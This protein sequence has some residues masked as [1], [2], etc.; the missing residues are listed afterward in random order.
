MNNRKLRLNRTDEDSHTL[1]MGDSGAGK[2]QLLYQYLDYIQASDELAIVLDSQREFLPIYFN[3]KRGDWVLNPKDNRCPYWNIFDEVSDITDATAIANSLFPEPANKSNEF[4]HI[5]TI[6]IFSWLL[7]YAKDPATGA[8]PN[9]AQLA[10]WLGNDEQMDKLIKGTDLV[11]KLPT[12]PTAGGQRA[13]FMATLS[14]ASKP[15]QLM[16]T[17]PEGRKR[18]CIRE[19]AQNPT[20]WVF[21][22]NTQETRDALR[23]LQ[24]MWLDMAILRLLSIGK[25][26]GRK[27]VW[28]ILDELAS[29][30]TLPQLHT[31]ITEGRKSSNP[32]VIGLQNMAQLEELYG[33]KSATIFSQA[34]TKFV[35]PT[36]EPRSAKALSDLIGECEYRRVR[37][38]R[39]GSLLG[40]KDRNSYSGPEEVRKPLILPSQIQGLPN[41]SGYMVQRGLVVP[42]K[43]PYKAR[44]KI[45]PGLIERIIPAP[46][47]QPD[48]TPRERPAQPIGAY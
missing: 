43:L 47:S 42:I 15:L 14:E 16:P 40:R 6:A 45:A 30:Q 18:L 22:T 37:E 28:I 26:A 1:A 36:T 41:L 19:W 23:P 20:G 48:N 21:L 7:A 24:S 5:G 31:A 3:E 46:A 32:M 29:L 10:D 17:D 33:Q 27:R 34:Y 38:T 25:Q 11:N 12:N 44:P 8:R 13:A 35:L 9:T 2:S 39:S 4:W